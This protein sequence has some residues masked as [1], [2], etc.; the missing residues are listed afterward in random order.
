MF[1]QLVLSTLMVILAV[2]FPTLTHP[3]G[4]GLVILML[5]I[6]LAVSLGL[7]MTNFW[8]SYVLILVLLGGLLVIFIYVSLLAPNE[9]FLKKNIFKITLSSLSMFIVL[10]FSSLFFWVTKSESY[11]PTSPT[12]SEGMLWLNS[13]YSQDLSGATLFLIFYLLLTLIVVVNITKHD[14]SSL[15][16]N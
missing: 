7:I 11:L 16:S 10:M 2:V 8:V 6:L 12:D 14:Y 5:S 4:M 13:L 9:L 15:R 3:L 1:V